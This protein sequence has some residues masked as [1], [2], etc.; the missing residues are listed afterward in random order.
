MRIRKPNHPSPGPAPL[1]RR[2]SPASK[3]PADRPS[4]RQF[5]KWIAAASG[6]AILE[7]EA[8]AEADEPSH[9]LVDVNVN[10]GRWPLRRVPGDEP[11]RLVAKLRSRG[12]TQAWA[13]SFEALLHKDLAAVNG[14]LGEDCRRHGRGRL[15]PFGSVNPKSPGWEEDLRRCVEVHR[16]RGLRL[17]P[18]YHGYRLDDP[19]FARLLA[20]AAEHRLLVQIALLMEDERMMHPLLRVAP[21]DPAPLADL[22]GRIPGLRLVL[23][24]A[25]AALHGE[26]LQKLVV[27]RDICVEISMLEG[28]GGIGSLLEQAPVERVLFGSYAPLFYFEAAELKLRESPLTPA[29]TQALCRGNAERLLG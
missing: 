2:H 20:L 4:R 16:M 8:P 14:R 25:P 23:V 27:A 21:V 7:A 10:L 9:G 19:A 3:S 1:G 24:N 26:L 18:N 29:Q 17:H 15:L 11:D 13:G 6:T 22:A 12:V 5:I 28:V